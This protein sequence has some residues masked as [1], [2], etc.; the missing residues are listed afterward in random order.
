MRCR[1]INYISCKNIHPKLLLIR[2]NIINYQRCYLQMEKTLSG[3]R[4]YLHI[5]CI[6]IVFPLDQMI[7]N[8]YKNEPCV[9]TYPLFQILNLLHP[10][11]HR[12]KLRKKENIKI[13]G[14]NGKITK[15]SYMHNIDINRCNTNQGHR[16]AMTIQGTKKLNL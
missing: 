14:K 15:P 12:E 8:H 2:L 6:F 1:K 5:G 13:T 4:C 3:K 9:F 16:K 7:S 10:R 11:K